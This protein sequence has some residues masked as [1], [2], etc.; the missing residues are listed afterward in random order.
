MVTLIFW[1][2]VLTAV[3]GFF[4]WATNLL[5]TEAVGEKLDAGLAIIEFGRAYPDEAIRS[6]MSSANGEMVFLRLWTGRTGVMRRTQRG[7]YCHLIDPAKLRI[8][9]TDT[10]RGLSLEF[11]GLKS[12]NGTFE[13]RD[14][15]EAAEVSLWILGGVHP[16]IGQDFTVPSHA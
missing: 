8:S 15:R 12:L 7:H 1:L 4:F 3:F 16:A 14:Q 11:E 2:I 9:Q 13:F 10:G 6:L 5:D